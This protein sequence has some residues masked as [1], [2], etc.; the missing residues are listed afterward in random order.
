MKI[1][2]TIFSK[3]NLI[4][5]ALLLIGL[6]YFCLKSNT[7][8]HE[9]LSWDEVHYSSLAD[10]G[11]VYN[12]LEKNS[13]NFIGFYKI[14]KARADKD[15]L[16]NQQ[17]VK[18]YN[19]PDENL[20]PFYLRHYHPPLATY[21][22]SFF[23]SNANIYEKD[24]SLRFSN[25]LL[26]VF[27]ILSLLISL[28]I[29]KILTAQSFSSILIFSILLIL[30]D[31][32]NYSFETLNFHTFQFLFSVIFVAC[33][34]RWINNQTKKNALFVGVSTAF[35]FLSLETGLFVVA[36]AILALLLT[37][38]IK[39]IFNFSLQIFGSFF[40]TIIA[41]WPGILKTLAP[42]KTWI[43]YAARIFLKG[44]DEY[45]SVDMGGA[46]KTM[47]YENIVLFT[48]IIFTVIILLIISRKIAKNKT[49]IIPYLV[50]FTYF[51]AI[52][53][54]IL[55]KTYI[56]PV[57]GLLIF[58]IVYNISVIDLKEFQYIK[59]NKKIKEYVLL[60]LLIGYI[61]IPFFN[62]NYTDN[63]NINIKERE[64]FNQDILE[65]KELLNSKH[66][67]IAFNG[68]SLRYYLQDESIVDLRKNSMQ[69]PGYYIRENGLYKNV[70][71][72]LKMN[73]IGAVVIPKNYLDY[74]PASK[75]KILEDYNYK[76]IKLK[77][78]E[79]F[80]SQ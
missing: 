42:V 13:L 2:T 1:P 38:Q 52:T 3:S 60:A 7:Y 21:Y 55:N 39:V 50:A 67:I 40:I 25:I 33:L 63:I 6:L 62:L 14:G 58:A 30:S 49:Y 56:F 26:G 68:Q 66:N 44:N 31:I 17:L 37:K 45:D 24:K 29:A 64:S 70:T 61:F 76:K 53:P 20:N 5:I 43:M 28:R 46:W 48:V 8:I 47:F 74:Y 23:T 59:T 72:E 71:E 80:L 57:I 18:E 69:N 78:F 34:I 12:A 77:H 11:I 75:T 51:I 27:T 35:M 79:V 22:W 9:N 73:R 19:Y 16:L 65:L 54:F 36:G 41:L 4:L 15:T 32:F 10:K